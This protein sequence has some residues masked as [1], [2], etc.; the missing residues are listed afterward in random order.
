MNLVLRPQLMVAK[1]TFYIRFRFSDF[2]KIRQIDPDG[3]DQI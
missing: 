1:M 2:T 3:I